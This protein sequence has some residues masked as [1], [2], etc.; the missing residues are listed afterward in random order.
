MSLCKKA[1]NGYIVNTHTVVKPNTVLVQYACIHRCSVKPKGRNFLLWVLSEELD[2]CTGHAQEFTPGPTGYRLPVHVNLRFGRNASKTPH[3]V[4]WITFQQ[5]LKEFC[6]ALREV[7]PHSLSNSLLSGS[8]MSTFHEVLKSKS[9]WDQAL[10]SLF[11]N[12]WG[13]NT[14]PWHA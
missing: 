3:N 13:G 12:P 4:S 7:D 8:T 5:P 6:W 9:L 10:G 1:K 11:S 14:P 2:L